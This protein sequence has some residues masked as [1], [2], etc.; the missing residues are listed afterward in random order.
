[1]SIHPLHEAT[2]G[3][4]HLAASLPAPLDIETQVLLRTFLVPVI[5][6]ATSWPD[7]RKALA[8]KGYSI[9]F[10][11]GRLVLV[12]SDTGQP[13]CTGKGL[14]VPLRDLAQRLGRPIVTMNPGGLTAELRA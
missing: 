11:H 12:S 8:A 9:G 7:L 14:G 6:N 5:E 1:M 3:D 13:V 4:A 2:F 10:R